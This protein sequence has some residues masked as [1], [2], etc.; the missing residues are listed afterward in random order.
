MSLRVEVCGVCDEDGDVPAR[1]RLTL[2]ST[3]QMRGV[4]LAA[5]AILR[6]TVALH[7]LPATA[8]I[9]YLG[10]PPDKSQSV[11]AAKFFAKE[12]ECPEKEKLEKLEAALVEA[13]GGRVGRGIVTEDGA[14]YPGALYFK[15]VM[16]CKSGLA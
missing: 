4:L 16:F 7:R 2:P 8:L 5:P 3:A 9:A 6:A 12:S 15:Q 13:S 11:V 14:H 10:S 1:V